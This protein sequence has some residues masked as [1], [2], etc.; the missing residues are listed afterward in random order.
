MGG[1]EISAYL[2]AKNLAKRMDVSVLTSYFPGLKRF[3]I[4]DNIKIYR[5]LK[6]GK[7]P[8]SLI[9]NINRMLYFENSLKKEVMTLC[10]K[11]N[12]DIIHCMNMTSLAAIDLKNMVIS[13]F[14][15]HINSPLVMCPKGDLI[16]K[17]K[18]CPGFCS[19]KKFEECILSSDEVGKMKNRFLIKHNF[20]FKRLMYQSYIL[21]T[22]RIK[23]FDY[24]FA[25]SNFLK[26]N[27]IKLNKNISLVPNIIDVERFLKIKEEGNER[28]LFLGDYKISK[29]P[30]ILLEALSGTKYKADFYGDGPLK[31]HLVKFKKNNINIFGKVSYKNIVRVYQNH[32]LVVFPSIWPEPF[33]RIAIEA[34]A[35]GKAV[36]G[37]DIG[38]IKD[39]IENNKTGLLVGAGN[40]LGLRRAIEKLM[41]N[42]KLRKKLGENGR[43]KAKKVYNGEII[44]KQVLSLYKRI[45]KQR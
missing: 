9:G 37:S 3:E 18:A 8:S 39:T 30:H 16:Y 19:K 14:I 38:G 10:K 26:D 28:I 34:M 33:G 5:R 43:K 11:E 32:S 4:K 31:K 41:K 44:S 6:T 17:G 23:K 36:V 12:F 13:K 27:L 45:I 25:I 7:S 20:L 42:K 22:K 15:A 1:G 29:G 2:L 21:K 24:C 40:I 35:A